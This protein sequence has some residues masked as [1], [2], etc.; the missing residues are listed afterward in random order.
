MSQTTRA[1]ASV[2]EQKLPEF[3]LTEAEVLKR[4]RLSRSSLFTLRAQGRIGYCRFGASIR[5]RVADVTRFI[6][7]NAHNG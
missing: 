4:L 2:A 7:E 3:L 1:I 6:E 5:Y